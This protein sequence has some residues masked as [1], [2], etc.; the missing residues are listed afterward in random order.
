[1][2][3]VIVLGFLVLFASLAEWEAFKVRKENARSEKIV[4]DALQEYLE[5]IKTETRKGAR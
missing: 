3:V 2:S 4:K 1:M 5:N